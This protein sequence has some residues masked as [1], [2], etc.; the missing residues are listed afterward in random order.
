MRA[1]SGIG[2]ETGHECVAG[3]S[4]PVAARIRAGR[5][6]PGL[7]GGLLRR[8]EARSVRVSDAG[9]VAD[10]LVKAKRLNALLTPAKD[11]RKSLLAQAA[12]ARPTGVLYGMPVA[13]KDNI[14]TL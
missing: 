7:Q 13:V 9:A 11:L 14:C 5:V 3:R 1:S 6:R 12:A 8:T 10:R 4:R 2:K